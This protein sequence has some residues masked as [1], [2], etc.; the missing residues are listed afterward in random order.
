M[1]DIII[2]QINHSSDNKSQIYKTAFKWA[3]IGSLIQYI[4]TLASYYLNG[5]TMNPDNKVLTI[6]ASLIGVVVIIMVIVLAI[7]EYRNQFSGGYV[8]FKRAFWVSFLC[9]LFLAILSAL[10][11]YLFYQ[12]IIDFDV[13]MSEQLD[14][15]ILQLKKRKLSEE[16]IN[17]SVTISKKF[18]T[19]PIMISFA[20][21]GSWVLNTLISLIASAI[22]K[23]QPAYE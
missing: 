21:I 2:D 22:L 13:M 15:T 7:K 12:F 16:Q 4:L 20:F 6:I 10:F 18:M 17:Q 23:K 14:Q 9:S 3:I 8:T 5:Q 19:M 11:M 1:T